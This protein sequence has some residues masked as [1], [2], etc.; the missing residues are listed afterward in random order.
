M[1]K[2]LLSIILTLC[3]VMSITPL[4]AFAVT[5]YGIWIGDEQ[6]TSDKTWSKQGWK[7]DIQSKTLTL[8]GYNMATIGKRIN[9]NSERPSRFGLIY[10]EGEQD[11][12][13]KLVGS[14]DLGDSP[15]SSQA[16]TKYNESYSGIYA[17]DSNITIIGS[18]TFSAVTHDA[19]IYCSNLT[20]GD[21]TEQNATNVS[22]ES[23]GACIIVKYNMIVNDYS[24]VWACANG[25]TVGMNGIYVEGSLYVNGTNTTVEG[26]ATY[27]PVKGECT[28]YTHYRPKNLTSGGY[29]NNAGST[30]AGIMVYGILTVDG[31]KVEGNVFKEIYKPQE[32]DSEYTSGLEAGGIVIKNN[33][34]VEGRN[35]NPSTPGFM[36]YGVQVHHYAI[37]FLGRGRVRAGTE[38]VDYESVNR[39]FRKSG[40][41]EITVSGRLKLYESDTCPAD[42]KKFAQYGFGGYTEYYTENMDD[43]YI[44]DDN[45]RG[46]MS[47]FKDMHDYET[48]YLASGIDLKDIYEID[49]DTNV[50][51][52]VNILS[53]D[54]KMNIDIK[55]GFELPKIIV[56]DG[57]TLKLKTSPDKTYNFTYPIELKGGTIEFTN[58]A[59]V[60]G[61]NIVGEGKVIIDSGNYSGT[62]GDNVILQISGG[63]ADFND[64]GKAVDAKGNSVH[65]YTYVARGADG[66]EFI[67]SANTRQPPYDDFY[68]YNRSEI[69]HDGN[70]LHLWLKS[71]DS[72]YGVNAFKIKADGT[73]EDENTYFNLRY[74]TNILEHRIPFDPITLKYFVVKKNDVVTLKTMENEP[75]SLQDSDIRVE[76]YSVENDKRTKI[77]AHGTSMYVGRMGNSDNGTHYQA[78]V[79]YLGWDSKLN[80]SYTYDAYIFIDEPVFTAPDKFHLDKKAKFE[81]TNNTPNGAVRLKYL[82]EVSKDGGKTFTAIDG[83]TSSVYEPT[84]ESQMNGWQ[85]RCKTWVST[86]D[87]Q[88]TEPTVFGPVT[89]NFSEK[90]P[91]IVKHPQSGATNAPSQPKPVKPGEITIVIERYYFFNVEATGSEPLQY[92]WQESSDNGETFVDI[93]HTNDNSHSL[94]VRKENNGKLVRSVVSNEYGSVVSNAAKLTIYYSPE[95]TA[96][97]GNK[98]INSGE[99]ATFT[100]PIVQGNPYGAEVM[101]QVSKDDGKTFADV[102]EADGTFS[103]D[104]KVVDGK[105]KWSTTFTTCATNISFNGYMYRCTVKNAEN[106]DYVGTWVSE[107][108]TLT[109][110]RNCAVD[111]HI[112]DEGTIISEP[113]CIDKGV[114]RFNCSKCSQYKDEP[115]NPLGHDWKEATCTAPKTCKRC[116][117]TEGEPIEHSFGDYISDENGHW[118]QCSEC[119]TDSQKELHAYK[120]NTEDGEYWQECTICGY[121]TKKSTILKISINGTDETCPL[122]DYE[123]TFALPE[124]C[125]DVTVGFRFAGDGTE[126]AFTAK[127]DLYTAKVSASDLESGTMTVYASAKLKDGFVIS[128]EKEVTVLENHV[129]GT[130]TCTEKAKCKFCNKE[131][132]D[133]DPTN[134]TGKP[135]WDFDSKEHEK[136]YDC[137]G[138][139]TIEREPHEWNAG[140]CT[141][142]GYKCT[143]SGGKATC[144][145]KATCDICGSEYGDIDPNNHGKLTHIDKVDATHDKEGNIEYWYCEECG[146]YFGDKDGTKEIQKADTIT[147]KLKDT[148]SDD[149]KD[150]SKPDKTK[151]DTNESKTDSSTA[152]KP[153]NDSSEIKADSST[154]DKPKSEQKN[155]QTG[156]GSG[157]SLWLAMLLI[158]GGAAMGIKK[159]HK[160]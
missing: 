16:A 24:T 93:P 104:S 23:F 76:W 59:I 132:G 11:L 119:G 13:I 81:V 101:W 103:L 91:V 151:D 55:S 140:E 17:P 25:P 120:W 57:A 88:K 26:R 98:T 87:G 67:G 127:D 40:G 50:P 109:V 139:V 154:A 131:Y 21:G 85:I 95:F 20:I 51:F 122:G 14:I 63:S 27:R 62:L 102:T 137:C 130:A 30:I 157:M 75:S 32:Y 4:N 138:E 108:A 12:N 70:K 141:E 128:G 94:K 155:P 43:I 53:G 48:F 107:K 83:E 78:D 113:T 10:V 77:N 112:F 28:N 149:K 68:G 71:Q 15:F 33:A 97:L 49:L 136:K 126:L 42:F 1:K 111:G 60:R 100:L 146:K 159:K 90:A 121:E 82:W 7:Y 22:C 3:M 54:I 37:K 46:K 72:I 19:A 114:K 39:G 2:R 36:E 73:L 58:S 160:K 115:I 86:G 65:K 133:L 117:A 8:L 134:H 34:T 84:I 41:N 106:A 152:E 110:I 38:Y 66:N 35:I 118:K 158:S 145:K 142:C 44:K 79:Y 153:K 9:G 96:S 18:G 116:Q 125:T 124:G 80:H 52:D 64:N 144:T 150:N 56:Y 156:S 61:L 105:E 6:V 148:P 69:F 123:F 92:Q 74:G 147:D 99:K 143:H 89:I 5:E 47:Y 45:G 129:G 31:S 29:F 135:V